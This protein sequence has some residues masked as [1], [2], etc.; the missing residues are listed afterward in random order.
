MDLEKAICSKEAT[1]KPF[2]ML[3]IILLFFT[4]FWYIN[5]FSVYLLGEEGVKWLTVTKWVCC[6]TVFKKGESD[7]FV[8]S[9][10]LCNLAITKYI[11]EGGKRTRPFKSYSLGTNILGDKTYIKNRRGKYTKRRNKI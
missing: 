4:A 6:R 11:S 8:D 5:F 7:D 2:M 9:F 3:L 10:M 1:M